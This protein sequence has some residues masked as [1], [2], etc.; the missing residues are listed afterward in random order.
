MV[1]QIGEV[2]PWHKIWAK[3]LPSSVLVDDDGVLASF[4]SLEASSLKLLCPGVVVSLSYLLYFVVVPHFT[5]VLGPL[6]FFFFVDKPQSRPCAW[7][8]VVWF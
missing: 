1:G 5:L 7:T 3:A 8:A 6:L 2:A 4:S